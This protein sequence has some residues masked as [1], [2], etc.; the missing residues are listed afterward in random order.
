MSKRLGGRLVHSKE[1]G[2]GGKAGRGAD[3]REISSGW[4]A[5][6]EVGGGVR[7]GT[8]AFAQLIGQR[9]EC[10]VIL[11]VLEIVPG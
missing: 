6:A 7:V 8:T 10:K 9:G 1:Q 5:S 2:E 11:K 3:R 4:D